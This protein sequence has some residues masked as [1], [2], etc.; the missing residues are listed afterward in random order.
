MVNKTT[1]NA[2]PLGSA[3]KSRGQ[4]FESGI[5]GETQQISSM[6]ISS[7]I[8]LRLVKRL[9]KINLD[10]T[11]IPA[12]KK[13]DV[14]VKVSLEQSFGSKFVLSAQYEEVHQKVLDQLERSRK[15][16]ALDAILKKLM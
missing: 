15:T 12:Q 4:R 10:L 8:K 3:S 6:S 1:L 11:K 14:F 2:T 5:E 16:A 9:R 13:R 7:S